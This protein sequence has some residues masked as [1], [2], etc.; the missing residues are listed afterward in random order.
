[1]LDATGM[2]F[3]VLIQV[4]VHGTDNGVMLD[5]LRDHPDRLR[6]VAVVEPDT[7]ARELRR[8]KD[9]GVTGLRLNVLYGGGVGIDQVETYG[10]LCRDMAGTFSFCSTP[11]ICRRWRPDWDALRSQS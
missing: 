11:G 6:G 8:L 2:T 10:D 4:S 9:A 3:G 1:M 5:A 7:P